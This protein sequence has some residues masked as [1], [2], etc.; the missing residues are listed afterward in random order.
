MA[1][2]GA[3]PLAAGP[4]GRAVEVPP[5]RRPEAGGGRS[6]SR[7]RAMPARASRDHCSFSPVLARFARVGERGTSRGR[8]SRRRSRARSNRRIRLTAP[9]PEQLRQ[10]ALAG[11]GTRSTPWTTGQKV[12]ETG[13]RPPSVS[14]QPRRGAHGEGPLHRTAGWCSSHDLRAPRWCRPRHLVGSARSWLARKDS[15]LRSPDPESGALPLGHSPVE[16]VG[17]I[18]DPRP[19]G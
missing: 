4:S 15:N 17:M 12:V 10:L 1:G 9:A 18:P 2:A 13:P 6:S 16:P 14:D 5:S 19:P 3:S 8:R 7:S 11:R